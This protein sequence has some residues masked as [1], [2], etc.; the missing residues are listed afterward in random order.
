M[1]LLFRD[2]P[3]YGI[4]LI[5]LD[6]RFPHPLRQSCPHPK[7]QNILAFVGNTSRRKATLAPLARRLTFRNIPL[8][9]FMHGTLRTAFPTKK[10][11]DILRG[12]YL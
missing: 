5:F 7:R 1:G 2:F 8:R 3:P 10:Y 6:N 12:F 4:E 9:K 11:I